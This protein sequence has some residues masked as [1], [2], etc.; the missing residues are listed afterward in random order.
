MPGGQNS[1]PGIFFVRASRLG[2]RASSPLQGAGDA[3][4]ASRGA[5]ER[6]VGPGSNI[7]V[8]RCAAALVAARLALLAACAP[9]PPPPPPPPPPPRRRSRSS[10]YRPL[11]AGRARPISWR[12]RRVGADGAPPARSTAQSRP[13]TSACGTSARPG[14]SPRSTASGPSTSRSSTATRAFLKDNAKALT[15][16]NTRDRPGVHA[17]STRRATTA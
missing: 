8:F 14:T 17:R 5:S 10:R 12:S 2:L 13:T 6:F 1:P 16:A 4:S 15:A 3:P 9:A 11:P 7:V